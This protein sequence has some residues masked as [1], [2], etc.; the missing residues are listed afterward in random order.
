MNFILISTGHSVHCSYTLKDELD[1]PVRCC[2]KRRPCAVCV[3]RMCAN[4]RP[5]RRHS[6]QTLGAEQGSRAPVAPALLYLSTRT[7][8]VI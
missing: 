4:V 6:K 5:V 7:A 8:S 3:N 2:Q 1:F